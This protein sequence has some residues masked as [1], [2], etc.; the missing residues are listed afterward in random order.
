MPCVGMAKGGRGAVGWLA[1]ARV[2]FSAHESEHRDGVKMLG[3]FPAAASGGIYMNG[4][5]YIMM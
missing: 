1:S 4:T 2:V 5:L 3:V